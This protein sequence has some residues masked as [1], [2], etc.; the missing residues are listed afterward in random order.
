[1]KAKISLFL[2]C[3]ILSL[4]AA[5]GAKAPAPATVHYEV[6]LQSSAFGNCGVRKMWIKGNKMRWEGKSQRLPMCIVKNADGTFLIH[7][8]NKIAAQ[9]P[10]GSLRSNPKA[11]FPGPAG[12][13]QAFLKAMKAEKCGWQVVNEK[14]CTIY[15]YMDPVSRRQCRIW[16]NDKSTKPVK[17]LIK[18]KRVKMDTLTAT[19]TK[20]EVGKSISD[21]LFELPKGYAIRPM[22]DELKASKMSQAERRAMRAK[23]D[24]Q[25]KESS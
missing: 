9:Y 18:G 1:L 2:T 6:K 13:I 23:T 20:Y 12:S 19:Y 8:W 7:P 22:P 16:I 11:I 24:K 10:K 14:K 15:T 17:L 4:G 25:K 5:S 21:S 3:A